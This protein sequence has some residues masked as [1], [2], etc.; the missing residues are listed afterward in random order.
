MLDHDLIILMEH[1]VV[2]TNQY[3]RT[4]EGQHVDFA[5]LTVPEFQL[6]F[7]DYAFD[8]IYSIA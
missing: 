3:A 2:Q 6:I 7:R 8:G 4:Q 5:D 1:I